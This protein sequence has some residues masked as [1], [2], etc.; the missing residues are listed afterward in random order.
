MSLYRKRMVNMTS[1]RKPVRRVSAAT[2][3][4]QGRPRRIVV[5][6]RPP[7]ILAFR[8][9]GCRREYALTIEACYAMAVRAHVASETKTKTSIRRKL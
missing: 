3:R 7:N 2:I 9:A 5:I 6:L 8:A 1:L 4:E